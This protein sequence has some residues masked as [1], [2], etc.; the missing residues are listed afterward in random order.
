MLNPLILLYGTDSRFQRGYC[1]RTARR[2]RPEF[3]NSIRQTFGEQNAAISAIGLAELVHGIYRAQTPEIR[4][5][6]QAFIDDLMRGI[7]TYPFATKAALLAGKINGEQQAKGV[8]IPFVDLLI[9]S[10]ALS[11]GFSVLTVNLRHFQQ[12]PNL[13]VLTF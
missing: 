5:R 10:T 8:I 12:V 4:V 7:P 9:A 6:R 2:R 11:V 3:L 1:G 13:R